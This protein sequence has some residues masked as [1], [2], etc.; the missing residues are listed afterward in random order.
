MVVSEVQ[1]EED[2]QTSEQDETQSYSQHHAQQVAHF[3]KKYLHEDAELRE[4]LALVHPLYL[5]WLCVVRM[6]CL[7]T[8][9]SYQSEQEELMRELDDLATGPGAAEASQHQHYKVLLRRVGERGLLP[10]EE[11]NHCCTYHLPPVLLDLFDD[12]AV[13]IAVSSSKNYMWCN[14]AVV[15]VVS[16]DKTKLWCDTTTTTV[17]SSSFCCAF[18]P[19]LMVFPLDV[20]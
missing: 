16:S 11:V 15:V 10:S 12:T 8:A 3:T 1:D 9:L 14:T 5:P 4:P 18:C 19:H 17:V 13:V 6:T 2:E 7:L 20:Q